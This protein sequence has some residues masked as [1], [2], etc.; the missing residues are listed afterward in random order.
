MKGCN[1]CYAH[2]NLS[3]REVNTSAG[4]LAYTLVRNRRNRSAEWAKWEHT[5]IPHPLYYED[6]KG[7]YLL[8]NSYVILIS[9]LKGTTSLQ[10]NIRLFQRAVFLYFCRTFKGVSISQ[11]EYVVFKYILKGTVS[12]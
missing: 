5:F 12:Y 9:S 6:L 11:Y 1:A 8:P 7:Q 2:S 3:P 4:R 10:E